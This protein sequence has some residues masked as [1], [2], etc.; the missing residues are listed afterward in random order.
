[1]ATYSVTSIFDFNSKPITDTFSIYFS[2]LIK[3]LMAIDLV[4][5]SWLTQVRFL[6]YPRKRVIYYKSYF[7][8]TSLPAMSV[9]TS[10]L[11]YTILLIQFLVFI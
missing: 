1:M 10:I 3:T 2:S 5:S 7:H 9:V 11:Y 8:L 4:T 6:N